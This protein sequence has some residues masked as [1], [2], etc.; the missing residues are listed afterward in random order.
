MGRS[1]YCLV[2]KSCLT[3]L[4]PDHPRNPSVLASRYGTCLWHTS[5]VTVSLVPLK[6]YR[7]K[8]T[9]HTNASNAT[10]LFLYQWLPDKEG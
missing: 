2:G 4:L 5:C 1:Y 8:R 3:P 9:F 7:L 10:P 6:R